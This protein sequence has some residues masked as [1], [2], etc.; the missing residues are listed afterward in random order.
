MACSLRSKVHHLQISGIIDQKYRHESLV[1][2][3]FKMFRR[4]SHLYKGKKSRKNIEQHLHPLPPQKKQKKNK[5]YEYL[6]NYLFI[7]LF[8]YKFMWTMSN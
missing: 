3:N 2:E 8:I 4:L 1:N 5:W 7:Y 6:F